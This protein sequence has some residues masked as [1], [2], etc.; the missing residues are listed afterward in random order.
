MPEPLEEAP[1]VLNGRIAKDFGLAVLAAGKPV[2]QMRDELG[3][4]AEKR[5]LCQ[6]NTSAAWDFC[7][8]LSDLRTPSQEIET[9]TPAIVVRNR[10]AGEV[11][12]WVVGSSRTVL[13]ECSPVD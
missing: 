4:F 12:G 1:Q 3:Q 8:R 13:I 6:P 10:C 7:S 9:R 2:G 11:V 5:L